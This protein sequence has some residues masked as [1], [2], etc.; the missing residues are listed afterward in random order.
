MIALG[1]VSEETRGLPISQQRTDDP[2]SKLT[3][4]QFY[5]V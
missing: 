5:P 2:V 3:P 4:G 1:R